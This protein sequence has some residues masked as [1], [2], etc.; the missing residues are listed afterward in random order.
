[1]SES[2]ELLGDVPRHRKMDSSILLVPFQSDAQILCPIVANS[3]VIIFIE[4][5]Q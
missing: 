3:E 5:V 1:M 4:A 2:F